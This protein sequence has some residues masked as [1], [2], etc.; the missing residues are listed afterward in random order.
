M[1]KML[2][3]SLALLMLIS[4]F[5]TAFASEN[6]DT[7]SNVQ[8][9]T[10]APNPINEL[11]ESI[12]KSLYCGT[13]WDGDEFHVIPVP[14]KL[15]ELSSAI[16]NRTK[17]RSAYP[18]IIIDNTSTRS[19]NIV[20]SMAQREN[21]YNYLLEHKDTLNIEAVGYTADKL[22]VFM[23]L[24]ATDEDR[25][26]VLVASPV[27][28]IEF[29]G[30]GVIGGVAQPESYEECVKEDFS[31]YEARATSTSLRGGN[32]LRKTST[33][34]WSTITVSAVRNWNGTSGDIGLLTC[35][36]GWTDGQSVYA[37]DGTKIGTAD[38]RHKYNMDVTFV[39]LSSTNLNS[40]G[41]MKDGTQVKYN[42]SVT[43]TDIGLSVEKY[44]AVTGNTSGTITVI[45]ISGTWEGY[46]FDNLFLT[47]V[48][49]KG[50]DSGS[51]IITGG[52]TILG[53]LKGARASSPSDEKP[54]P[55]YYESVIL[56]IK[57]VI[58]NEDLSP[59]T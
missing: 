31:T 23:N 30:G 18:S 22:A 57:D 52:D 9:M 35:G 14:A 53:I 5:V 38:V 37:S 4:M 32:W 40:H 39:K 26:N 59:C 29:Y 8:I 25:Q 21:G 1:K 48:S 20:Y 24:N 41:Y 19:S 45:G 16:S 11:F 34:N 27:K 46:E 55:T 42:R 49:T 15:D 6:T 2:S 50:G 3:L 47:S 54:N 7:D 13:Y 28:A 44:G 56:P 33:S 10:E 17:T 36:H 12:D 43:S 58:N 51:P